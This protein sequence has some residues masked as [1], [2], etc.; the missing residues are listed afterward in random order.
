MIDFLKPEIAVELDKQLS[1]S[2]CTICVCIHT[3][4]GVTIFSRVRCLAF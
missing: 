1:L 4:L 3:Q 2:I